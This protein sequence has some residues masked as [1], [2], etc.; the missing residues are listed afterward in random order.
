MRLSAMAALTAIGLG[1]A[2]V[3]IFGPII[4]VMAPIT[5]GPTITVMVPITTGHFFRSSGGDGEA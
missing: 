4:T 5:T 2:I 3:V 1:L